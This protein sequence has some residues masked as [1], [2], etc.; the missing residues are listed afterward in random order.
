MEFKTI[1]YQPGRVA[2]V[3][4]SR[5]QKRNAQDWT[6]LKELDA[7]FKAAVLDPQCR[8]IVLSGAGPSF[9]A[10]HDLQ[11]DEHREAERAGLEG[12]D[13]Y[14]KQLVRRDVYVESHLR[15][16]NLPKPT[17]AMV[18]G[19]CIFAG[20]MIASAMD[21]IFAADDALFIPTYGGYFTASWDLGP[22]K[23]KEFLFANEAL[24]A[25]EAMRW[26]FVN[27]VHA[28]AELEEATL[29]YANRVAD[30]NPVSNRMSKFVINKAQDAQGFADSVDL[31]GAGYIHWSPG[32]HPAPEETATL[33]VR[34]RVA[35][36]LEYLRLD[37]AKG[38]R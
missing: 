2:R 14:G 5:P 16:R 34:E 32:A 12:L 25:G 23:A 4:L 24:S 1:V 20:W 8:V 26:G 31:V 11:S 10:G 38:R 27:R 33:S 18:H 29:E 22:R 19:H 35:R 9:S 36:A 28:A 15:W 37:R 17:I 6:M 3:I 30:Q 21:L 13:A 7:A